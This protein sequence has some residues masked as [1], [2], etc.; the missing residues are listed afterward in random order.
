M[1]NLNLQCSIM[2]CP[3]PTLRNAATRLNRFLA[4]CLVA[5]PWLHA[6]MGTPYWR[7]FWYDMG[8]LTVHGV[9]S[10]VLFGLPKVAATDRVLMW[11]GIAPARM[12]PRTEFLFTGFGIAVTLAYL[13]GFSVM[14]WI[15]SALPGSFVVALALV[16]GLYLAFLWMLLPFRLIDHV[17][18]GVEYATARWR[19]Q[20]PNLRKDVAGLVLLLYVV[21]HLVN[22]VVAIGRSMFGWL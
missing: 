1:R 9:L 10:L 21:G 13:A 12:T 22:M 16:L 17:Y 14:F 3:V 15:G 19:V 20:N 7:G 2:A 18:K 4:W 5:T 8:L 11:L 6:V